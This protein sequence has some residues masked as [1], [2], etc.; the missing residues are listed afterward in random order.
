MRVVAH[1]HTLMMSFR[2]CGWAQKASVTVWREEGI[3]NTMMNKCASAAI[4][5]RITARIAS[6]LKPLHP[7][8]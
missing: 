1:T 8:S 5:D 6:M 7:E 3:V 2:R 4:V